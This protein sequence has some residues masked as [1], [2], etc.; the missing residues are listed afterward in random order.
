MGISP[1]AAGWKGFA[2]QVASSLLI[3]VAYAVATMQ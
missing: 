3:F 1:K 2:L